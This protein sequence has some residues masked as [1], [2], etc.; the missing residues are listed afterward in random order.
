MSASN[1]VVFNVSLV[2]QPCTFCAYLFGASQELSAV[3]FLCTWSAHAQNNAHKNNS[4]SHGKRYTNDKKWISKIEIEIEGKR[5]K[6]TYLKNHFSFSIGAFFDWGVY[7]TNWSSSGT[8]D[9]RSNTSLFI[10]ACGRIRRRENLTKPQSS[11]STRIGIKC[12]TKTATLSKITANQLS[13]DTEKLN[14]LQNE[15]SKKFIKIKSTSMFC[16]LKRFESF[17]KEKSIALT[18]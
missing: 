1:C 17:D 8:L 5:Q 13:S 15:R 4:S 9:S 6:E 3:R 16:E 12:K 7:H 18:S 14:V 11:N 2:R 10:T